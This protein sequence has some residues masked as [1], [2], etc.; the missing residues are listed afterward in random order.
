MRFCAVC[1]KELAPLEITSSDSD[2]KAASQISESAIAAPKLNTNPKVAAVKQPLPGEK[3]KQE[4]GSAKA[5]NKKFETKKSGAQKRY[6][7]KMGGTGFGRDRISSFANMSNDG[8]LRCPKCGGTNF[9]A[10]RSV[11][12]KIGIGLLAPKTQVKCIT[13]GKMFKRG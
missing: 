7:A 6:E 10:K 2:S 4:Q 12:G 5:Q 9:T 1:G 3:G 13:C 8:T 11:K